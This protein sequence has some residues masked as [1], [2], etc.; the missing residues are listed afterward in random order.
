MRGIL[1]DSRALCLYLLFFEAMERA[2]AI[3]L[4]YRPAVLLTG[5]ANGVNSGE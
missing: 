3:S 4:I 1:A 5:V 2:E